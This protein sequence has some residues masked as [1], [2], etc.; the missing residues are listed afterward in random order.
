MQPTRPEITGTYSLAEL[1][2]LAGASADLEDLFEDVRNRMAGYR[3][4]ANLPFLDLVAKVR[5]GEV[6]EIKAA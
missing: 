4:T 1:E 5:A 3:R 2:V 6:L